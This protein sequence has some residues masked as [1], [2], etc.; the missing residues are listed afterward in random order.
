M[1]R[2]FLFPPVRQFLQQCPAFRQSLPGERRN[3]GEFPVWEPRKSFSFNI[4]S[5]FRPLAALVEELHFS[6]AERRWL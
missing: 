5:S 4:V 3:P 6:M 2:G 1:D